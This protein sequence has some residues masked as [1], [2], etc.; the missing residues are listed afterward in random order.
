M[1]D[2]RAL[3]AG[4]LLA[5]G[6]NRR[7]Q[8]RD[9]AFLSIPSAPA[10]AGPATVAE[11]ALVALRAVA[12]DIVVAG[13]NRERFL[14][15]TGAVP[16]RIVADLHS[17]MGP[18]AGIHAAL[19]STTCDVAL[20]V[21]CDMPFISIPVLRLLRGLAFAAGDGVDAVVPVL[22]GRPEPLHAA[23]RRSCGEHLGA[24]LA[25]GGR[26]ASAALDGLRW[27]PVTER[28]LAAVPEARGSFANWNYPEQW[29]LAGPEHA[30]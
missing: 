11:R 22:D 25:G 5:G 24:F 26:K 19:L 3:C 28:D 16:F 9:K 10:T 2:Q 1:D 12:A 29:Q 14:P 4:I 13:G 21:A 8:G 15:L 30:K 17:G 27:L 6:A 7:L 23:Y 20:V 18:L